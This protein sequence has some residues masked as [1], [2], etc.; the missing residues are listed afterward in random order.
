MSAVAME[1]ASVRP[2]AD[3]QPT[4]RGLEPND[5][6]QDAVNRALDSAQR[7]LEELRSARYAAL[8]HHAR[9]AGV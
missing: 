7:L 6:T 8:A 2:E 9:E 4:G 3:Q 1:N 5:A